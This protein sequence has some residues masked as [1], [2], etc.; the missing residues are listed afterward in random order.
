MG[1]SSLNTLSFCSLRF[2]S[3]SATK[4]TSEFVVNS[5][6]D[7][8]S[9]CSKG[10]VIEAFNTFKCEI[11]SDPNLFS[12]LIQ[13]CTLK[14][15]LS[16]A[17]Q[18]HSLIVTSGCSSD[19]FICNHLLNMYSKFGQTQTVAALF[20]IMPRKNIMSCNILIN[21]YMQS[22]DLESARKVFEDMPDRN[23]ATWNA[24]VAGLI[25]FEFNGRV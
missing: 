3:R 14:N 5:T 6:Q 20:G 17:K 23:I 24:M 1:K 2:F 16:L 4:I 12:Q 9:L 21:A 25:Q 15:S 19:K 22:G 10:L 18:L 8:T 7:F 13:S 11:W